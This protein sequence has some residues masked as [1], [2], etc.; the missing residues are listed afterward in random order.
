VLV[1]VITCA[2][3]LWWGEQTVE[4]KKE[5]IGSRF[6]DWLKEEGIYERVTATAIKRAIADQI[7]EA[8]ANERVSKTEWRN[9]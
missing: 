1:L 5:N 3:V 9:G 4:I 7:E 2:V 8:M 6:D